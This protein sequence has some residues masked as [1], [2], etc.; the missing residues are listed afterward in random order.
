MELPDHGKPDL[1]TPDPYTQGRMHDMTT[2]LSDGP[3]KIEWRG[4]NTF[5]V[6]ALDAEVNVFSAGY[7]L[8]TSEL[9]EEWARQTAH[10]WW[11]DYGKEATQ[12]II[13]E[14]NY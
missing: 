9:T 12:E 14:D 11:T 8:P 6:F 2:V 4:G 1:L 5:N 10:E 3:F 7:E 13:R